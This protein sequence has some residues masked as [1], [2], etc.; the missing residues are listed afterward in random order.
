M[1]IT[2]DIASTA[3]PTLVTTATVSGGGD[4]NGAN[5]SSQNAV[6]L[7]ATPAFVPV[8]VNSPLALLITMLVVG[9]LGARLVRTRTANR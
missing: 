6:D 8:P 9:V 1:I 5:N 2:I 3:G 4:S 7:N